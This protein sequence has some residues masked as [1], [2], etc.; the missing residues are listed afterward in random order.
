VLWLALVFG[1][2][3]AMLGLTAIATGQ[4]FVFAIVLPFAASA[5]FMWLQ[6]SGRMRERLREQARQEAYAERRPGG[7]F[8]AGPRETGGRGARAREAR[9]RAA[10]SR[11]AGEGPFGSRRAR[12]RRA[13]AGPRPPREGADG[14]S[15]AEAAETL[16]VSPSA[17]EAAVRAAYR[18][19]VKEVHP[20]QGGDPETF[21]EVRDAYDTA[22]EHASKGAA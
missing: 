12:G 11:F 19:R 21:H 3:A 2:L 17:D 15:V 22:K 5:Y 18:D 1:A 14:P 9:E 7:T 13:G 6:G 16:D 20:D 4:V 10:G 8:G